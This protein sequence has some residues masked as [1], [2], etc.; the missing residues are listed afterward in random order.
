MSPPASASVPGLICSAR[1]N[2][3]RRVVLPSAAVRFRPIADFAQ[4]GFSSIT[5]ARPAARSVRKPMCL[6]VRDFSRPEEYGHRSQGKGDGRH[7]TC[8]APVTL[9]DA[10][11]LAQD[12]RLECRAEP[13]SGWRSDRRT[14]S[15][16]PDEPTSQFSTFHVTDTRPSGELQAPYLLALVASSWISKLRSWT[17]SGDSSTS[18]PSITICW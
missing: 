11:D 7:K 17:C 6:R 16:L 10:L 2:Q 13:L 14:P 1:R 4:A 5:Q 12:G 9:D 3:V 8:R 18:G 15:L